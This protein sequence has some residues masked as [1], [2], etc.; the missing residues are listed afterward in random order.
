MPHI[1]YDTAVFE[2]D[3]LRV[4]LR[5]METYSADFEMAK[6]YLFNDESEQVDEILNEIPE[7]FDLSGEQ[8]D[9]Y[10]N[11][12]QNFSILEAQPIDGLDTVAINK[13]V[14]IA[15]GDYG[16]APGW[17]KKILGLYGYYYPPIYH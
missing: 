12:M 13:L 8:L 11:L 15:D 4:W 17:A 7:K 1:A 9:D 10:D 2:G 6:S 16:F 3:S 14:Q 5:N